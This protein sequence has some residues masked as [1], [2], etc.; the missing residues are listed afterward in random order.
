MN[1]KHLALTL[2]LLPL[3]GQEAPNRFKKTPDLPKNPN[4]LPVVVANHIEYF[5]VSKETLH[6]WRASHPDQKLTHDLVSNWVEKNQASLAETFFLSTRLGK[7]VSLDA[8]QL[9][10]FPTEYTSPKFP[11]E[12]MIPVSFQYKKLG[13]QIQT[14]FKQDDQKKLFATLGFEDA[15]MLGNDSH[16]HFI[17]K[18]RSPEDLFFPEFKTVQQDCQ[19]TY[20]NGSP[21]LSGIFNSL[22]N[23]SQALLIFSA[24][25]GITLDPIPENIR[26]KE[27]SKPITVSSELIE[28]SSELWRNY[29]RDKT[30]DQVSAGVAALLQD[31]QATRLRAFSKEVTWGKANNLNPDMVQPSYPNSY[32]PSDPSKKLS[33]SNPLVPIEIEPSFG[34]FILRVT[35]GVTPSGHILLTYLWQMHTLRNMNVIHRVSDGEQWTPDAWAPCLSS[36]GL[37][38]ALFLSP[39]KNTLVGALPVERNQATTSP[40][41]MRLFFLKAE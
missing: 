24:A 21:H 36:F 3:H 41:K 8:G 38:G 10:T 35:P 32:K 9:L 30:P 5:L 7:N 12:W 37:R 40:T 26:T 13:H 11:G 2:L 31:Q 1:I 34:D 22:D 23:E 19:M 39:G 16:H 17:E 25:T 6:H 27:A 33:P 15:R 18:T 28:I 20:S 4:D 29:C 14:I